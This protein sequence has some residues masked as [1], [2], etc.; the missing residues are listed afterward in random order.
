VP[1]FGNAQFVTGTTTNHVSSTELEPKGSG[2]LDEDRFDHVTDLFD[3][4]E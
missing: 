1:R 4:V 3:R 2:G